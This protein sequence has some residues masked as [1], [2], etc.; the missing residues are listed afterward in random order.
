VVEISEMERRGG[1]LRLRALKAWRR[2]RGLTQKELAQ[3]VG[4]PQQYVGRIET[5]LRGCDMLVAQRLAETLAVNLREL[6]TEPEPEAAV[7][8]KA[9]GPRS[10]GSRSLHRAYLQM[11]LAQKV[12]S[13]YVALSAEELEKHCEG[14][15]CETVLEVLSSRRREAEFLREMLKGAVPHPEVL[16]FFEEVLSPYP[17]QDIRLLADA[18]SQERSEKGREELTR[19]MRE[20]P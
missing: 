20:L 9:G 8:S 13:A 5:G 11:L 7:V 17:D 14:L 6:Q 16:L 3:R 10:I 15:S 19:V 4:V 18:R 1:G 12:G 2:R